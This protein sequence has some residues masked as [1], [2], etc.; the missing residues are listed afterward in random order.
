MRRKSVSSLKLAITAMMIATGLTGCGNSIPDMTQ[1]QMAQVGEYAAITLLK[2]DANHRSRLVDAETVEA[3]D[4]KMQEL[5][6]LKAQLEQQKQ[7]TAPEGMKPVED[8]PTVELNG[9]TASKN[10]IQSLAESLTV[11]DGV[12][13]NYTGYKTCDTYPEDGSAGKYFTLDASAGKK[14]LVLEFAVE[15]KSAASASVD[16]FSKTAVFSVDA[17]EG[18]K[19]SAMT[20]MLLDDLSTYVGT[21]PAGGTQKLVLLFEVDESAAKNMKDVQLYLREESQTSTIQL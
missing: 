13:I 2:Y 12:E 7:E 3:Y 16:F 15:N 11:P 19:Y 21:I 6:A 10:M 1:E 8:T 20:T 17:G 4:R 18:K 5:E 14:L 9:E